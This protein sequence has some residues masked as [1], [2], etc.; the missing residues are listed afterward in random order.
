MRELRER[1]GQLARIL[2]MVLAA[3]VVYELAGVALRWNPFRGVAV[4]ALPELSAATN[5]PAGTSHSTNLLAHAAPTGTNLPPHQPPTNNAA[6]AMAAAGTNAASGLGSNSA[7]QTDMISSITNAR[8]IAT[9]NPVTNTSTGPVATNLPIALVSTNGSTNLAVATATPPDTNAPGQKPK[10]Q[11]SGSPTMP[12]MG[13]MPVMAG[14]PGMPGMGFNP[15]QPGGDRGPSLPP[16]VQARVTRITESELLAPVMHPLPMA[17]LGIAGDCAFLRADSG[18]TGLVK[19]GDSL[20][21]I[22]LLR[23]GINRVLVDQK[24]EKKELMIFAGY[25]GESLL[26]NESSNENK[27]P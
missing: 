9:A 6:S 18:Q 27:H 7:A 3:V 2:G 17:L 5:A 12:D 13:G 4:P 1:A 14:M 10:K 15:F 20:D 16:A 24:G 21:D 23:I 26:P 25:G 19:E 8:V 11:K 22:K